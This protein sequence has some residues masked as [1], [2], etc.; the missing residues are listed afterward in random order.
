MTR[1]SSETLANIYYEACVMDVKA[2]KP[3]NV[4]LSSP[5]HG[6]QGGDFL[7]SAAVSAAILAKPESTLGERILNAVVATREAVACNTNLGIVLLCAP[8]LQARLQHPDSDLSAAVEQIIADST[9]DDCAA[10]YQAIRVASPGGLGDVDAYDVNDDSPPATIL[11]AMRAAAGHD[12]IAA[13]YASGFRALFDDYVDYLVRSLR[14]HNDLEHAVTDLFLYLLANT[15]DTHIR[16]KQGRLAAQRVCELAKRARRHYAEAPDGAS[17]LHVLIDLDNQLKSEGLNPGTSADLCV[18][19][20]VI[21]RLQQ[22]VQPEAGATRIEAW[23]PKPS[24]ASVTRLSTRHNDE[25]EL[26]WQ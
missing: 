8:L 19:A 14:N 3:G 1:P 22:Q 9:Q 26:K 25:G 13:L 24:V 5:G 10:L 11:Q 15:P 18:A 16:R 17:A 2:L 21:F 20:L 12:V 4:S 7:L 6:M 23:A